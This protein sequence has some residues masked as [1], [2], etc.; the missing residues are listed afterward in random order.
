MPPAT[1]E[2]LHVLGDFKK[3]CA[4]LIAVNEPRFSQDL[5]LLRFLRARKFDLDRA[6]QMFTAHVEWYQANNIGAVV[7]TVEK[8]PE[9]WGFISD[10]YPSKLIG[11]DPHGCLVLVERLFF[12]DFP[13]LLS[14]YTLDEVSYYHTYYSELL[15]RKTLAIAT[16][17]GGADDGLVVV[18]DMTHF[19]LQH[20]QGP[21]KD[22][23]QLTTHKLDNHYPSSL[24][25]LYIICAPS[26]FA[27][28]W[29]LVKSWLDPV[30]IGKMEICSSDF[31]A[32]LVESLSPEVVP[33]AWGGTSETPLPSAGPI[34]ATA[35]DPL[36]R[37]VEVATNHEVKVEAPA[38]AT[39]A[40]EFK[41]AA[42]DIG[43]G[44]FFGPERE[45]V[46]PIKR[47]ECV[48]T[49]EQ[50]SF[51]ATRAGTYTLFFDNS[52]SLFRR[53]TVS[54]TVAVHV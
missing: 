41:L 54:F 6:V 47:H 18:A 22:L 11:R 19:G 42:Y 53:K 33:R 23:L 31:S 51:V 21:F 34:G 12:M 7:D 10:Y 28:L 16:E 29:K 30:T 15:Q 25:K 44:I 52:F 50:G 37:T 4:A 1:D 45:V 39:I 38:G 14:K 9:K 46:V 49:A 27:V 3:R 17:K 36:S 40:Y 20:L 5:Y 35:K 32:V 8:N 26:L 13:G 43:F 24:K 2:Q 48:A